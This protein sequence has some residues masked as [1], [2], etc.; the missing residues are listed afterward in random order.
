[1]NTLDLIFKSEHVTKNVC[2]S[3]LICVELLKCNRIPNIADGIIGSFGVIYIQLL[4]EFNEGKGYTSWILSL[5]SGMALCAGNFSQYYVHVQ[6]IVSTIIGFNY[7]KGPISSSF[8]NKYGFRAVTISGSIL[9]A[10][11]LFISSYAQNVFTL[12]ITI[13]K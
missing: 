9:A 11:S 5:M 8:V 10:A 1:M 13:G 7:L 6:R 2:I 3:C 12:I 4:D